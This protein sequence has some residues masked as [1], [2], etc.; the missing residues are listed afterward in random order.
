MGLC[1]KSILFGNRTT[2]FLPS[3][4][5]EVGG[6]LRGQR[7]WVDPTSFAGIAAV[8]PEFEAYL[9]AQLTYG[10][11]TLFSCIY[12]INFSLMAPTYLSVVQHFKT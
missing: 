8:L 3:Q 1:L 10:E 4:D 2:H 6:I 9:V 12:N 5:L 7:R 11:A